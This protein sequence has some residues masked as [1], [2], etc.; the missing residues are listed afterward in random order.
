MGFG[1]RFRIAL[2]GRAPRINAKKYQRS[3]HEAY[4]RKVMTGVAVGLSLSFFLLGLV[5]S[6]AGAETSAI[7]CNIQKAIELLST[8]CIF[9]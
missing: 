9:A 6:Q 3:S 8:F 5:I 4:N 1:V 2:T 7:R